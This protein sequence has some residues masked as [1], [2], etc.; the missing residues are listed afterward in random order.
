MDRRNFLKTTVGLAGMTGMAALGLGGARVFAGGAKAS[1]SDVIVIGAG[2][3]GLAAAHVLEAAGAR[4]TVLEA[5]DRVGGR[6]QT[7]ERDG[8]R[9]EVGGV[10]V[11]A[12][13]TRVHAHAARVGVTIAPPAMVIQRAMFAGGQTLLVSGQILSLT[14]WRD[15]AL[16]TLKGREHVI[17][18]PGLLR[19]AMA[20]AALPRLAGWDDP[21]R[22]ALD[23][24]LRDHL[25]SRGWSDQ[26]LDWMDVADSYT[27]L[28]TISALDALRRDAELSHS[29]RAA[30]G[31]VSG[32]SQALP[33]AMAASLQAPPLLRTEVVSI[34]RS[35]RGIEVTCRNGRR[36]RADH[37][38]VTVPSGPLS[39]IKI[40]PAPP[41]AQAAVWSRRR[42]NSV[43][44]IHLRPTRA[45]WES[46]GNPANM[47]NDG[48]IQRVLAVPDSDG[49]NDRLIVWLNGAGADS[50]DK[51]APAKRMEWAIAE[52]ARLRPASKGA[53]QPLATRSWGND[54]FASGAFPEIAP[55]Q[56][57]QT[58]EWSGK[59]LG[60]IHFAGSDTV[61][62][63]PGMEAA[64]VSGERAAAAIGA[65]NHSA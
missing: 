32:G 9:F 55:G 10:Q 44:T 46:D 59:T 19:A 20:D 14:D 39:R 3:A 38:I 22:L 25:A 54:P 2:L 56:V 28:R 23:I 65:I 63:K 36:Y 31:W 43:T 1:R 30:P 40:D 47:W 5:S 53:L 15:S 17:P 11:G 42:S 33:I 4:V 51:Y 24:P 21:E 61:F 49:K 50:A 6:L 35:A 52:L 60:R 26:A 37:L 58:V 62:D 27:S 12:G 18:P 45:F 16:N 7:I 8:M 48:P 13:Y 34:A 29:G 57:A 41:A 64:V